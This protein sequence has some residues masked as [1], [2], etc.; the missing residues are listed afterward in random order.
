MTGGLNNSPGVLYMGIVQDGVK[1][2]DNRICLNQ[3]C[4][5][6]SGV[7]SYTRCP[8]NVPPQG[9]QMQEC[10]TNGVRMQIVS[11]YIFIDKTIFL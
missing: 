8:Q 6:I 7:L 5:D 3:T 1:C 2:G 10:S 4:K 11:S 9:G